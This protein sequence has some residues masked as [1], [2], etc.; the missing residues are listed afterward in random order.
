M[1][2]IKEADALK[3]RS[4]IISAMQK[5]EHNQLWHGIQEDK[6]EDFWSVNVK[7]ME[8]T[9]NE[10][11]RCIPFRFY[12]LDQ[13]YIQRLFKPFNEDSK[14]NTLGDLVKHIFTESND[15]ENCDDLKL[16][17]MTHGIEPPFETPIQW[18]SEHLSYP[19]NFLHLCVK[20]TSKSSSPS[21]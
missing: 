7:L 21:S 1:S 12:Q 10:L 5:K 15:S 6:F 2:T 18:M 4:Q 3:H 20:S 9:N 11:F 19:D 16:K 17:V 14:P 13:P 8:H